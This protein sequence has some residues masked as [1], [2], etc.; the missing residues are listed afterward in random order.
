MG[1]DTIQLSGIKVTPEASSGKE[2][3]EHSGVEGISLELEF[4]EGRQVH[5]H[6]IIQLY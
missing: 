4:V 1:K 5:Q 2:S 6:N 3:C